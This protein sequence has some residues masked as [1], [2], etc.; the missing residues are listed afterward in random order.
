[1]SAR[2]EQPVGDNKVW[3]EADT[4]FVSRRFMSANNLFWL[5]SYNQTDLRAGYEIGNFTIEAYLENVFKN[6]DPR[7][8]S[9]T[10]DYGYFDLNSFNLPRAALIALA[11]RQTFG[12]KIGAKF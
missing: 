9:S 3:I 5:P 12:L 6:D 11:P 10:V 7:T 8:G 2:F 1:M 4:R